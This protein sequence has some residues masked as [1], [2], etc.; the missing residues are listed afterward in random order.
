MAYR[1][2]LAL[3]TLSWEKNWDSHS[4]VNGYPSFYPRIALVAP[5]PD[6]RQAIIWTNAAILLF[7]PLG[8]NFCEI[9][10]ETNIFIQENAFENVGCEMATILSRPQC[11]KSLRSRYAFMPHQTSPPLVQKMSWRLIG[12]QAI[13]WTNDGLLLTKSSEI[14]IET[15]NISF[16]KMHLKM[17]SAKQRPFVS[18]SICQ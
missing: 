16:K 18:A 3:L 14:L 8:T 6:R 12:F 4:L 15:Y 13:I 7:G 10:I 1:L 9:F 11:V 5:S 2:G 17:S